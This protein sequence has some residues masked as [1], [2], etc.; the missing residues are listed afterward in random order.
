M[1]FSWE[2]HSITHP[3]IFINKGR[4]TTAMENKNNKHNFLTIKKFSKPH[5]P[6]KCHKSPVDD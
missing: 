1:A 4:H 2:K 3:A 6:A 5:Y